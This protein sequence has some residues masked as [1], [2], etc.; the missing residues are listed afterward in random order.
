[1][2]S[3]WF[4]TEALSIHANIFS[5]KVHDMKFLAV[6]ILVLASVSVSFSQ[7][8]E[9]VDRADKPKGAIQSINYLRTFIIWKRQHVTQEALKFG[10]DIYD[11]DGNV[12]QSSTFG[13]I[14]ER[15]T[16]SRTD[17]LIKRETRYY[18]NAGNP[19]AD[20]LVKFEP[21]WF[22]LSK[23]DLCTDY[24]T[25]TD[26]DDIGKVETK[27][28]ICKDGSVRGTT[29]YERGQNGLIYRSFTKDAK[30]RTVEFRYRY[31]S[32]NIETGSTYI[33]ND[34]ERPP[35]SINVE[36]VDIQLDGKG[37]WVR[38]ITTAEYST[39]P[40]EPTYL[41]VEEQVIK[42]YDN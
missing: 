38:C 11:H 33:V 4:F 13:N 30:G 18:D 3:K 17:G 20:R 12:T 10:F 1:M 32:N 29:T 21:P 16:Y 8:P 27:T 28:D 41:Y 5:E 2:Q 40:H 7:L 24:S 42:Y 39:H 19:V 37:N 9:Q 23:G 25:R 34:L 22:R 15:T 36:S 6:I 26:K 31:D 14:E 35:F